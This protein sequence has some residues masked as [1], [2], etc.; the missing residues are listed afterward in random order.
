MYIGIGGVATFKN[1]KRCREVI[2]VLPKERLLLETDAPYLAPE[3][4]RGKTCHSAM[5]IRTAE[6]ISDIWKISP[7]EVLQTAKQNAENLF[8][9]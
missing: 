1:A 9:I 7:L 5:I 3:P 8:K 4:Y 2:E 6:V